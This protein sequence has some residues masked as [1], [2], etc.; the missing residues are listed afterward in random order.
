MPPGHTIVVEAAIRSSI[1]KKVKH[2]KID[3]VLRHR[4]I[5]MCG[6]NNTMVGTK[7][8]DP[9]LCLYVGAYLICVLDNKHLR[10]N[11]PRGNGTLFR[12]VSMKLKDYTPSH[13]WKN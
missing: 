1:S 5:T 2:V 11:I 6:D 8:I 12:V 13:I 7:H 9:S 4:I 10:E 3:R